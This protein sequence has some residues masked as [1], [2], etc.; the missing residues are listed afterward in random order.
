MWAEVSRYTS[1]AEVAAYF[2]R[3]NTIY[4]WNPA[5]AAIV[6]DLQHPFIGCHDRKNI[7]VASPPPLFNSIWPLNGGVTATV[8]AS[9]S[10]P[11]PAN[12][13]V[14]IPSSYPPHPLLIGVSRKRTSQRTHAHT[15][16]AIKSM[17]TWRGQGGGTVVIPLISGS[18]AVP[19]CVC[20]KNV[21]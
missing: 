2:H 3:W 20:V 10:P 11:L 5:D 18:L 9:T 19:V 6:K 15:F 21:T 13:A 14:C 4:A 16:V 1:K 7:T 17:R 8:G 12:C